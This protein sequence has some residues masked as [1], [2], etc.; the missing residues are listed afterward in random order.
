MVALSDVTK[1]A[2]REAEAGGRIGPGVF[3][4]SAR[5]LHACDTAL[6]VQSGTVPSKNGKAAKNLLELALAEPGLP[7]ERR[8]LS[9]SLPCLQGEADPCPRRPWGAVPYQGSVANPAM[10]AERATLGLPSLTQ[11][12]WEPAPRRRS[13]RVADIP[14]QAETASSPPPGKR[15][16]LS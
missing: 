7:D 10:D 1:E 3:R 2:L 5:V 11:L 14:G 9:Q 12:D 4:D 8:H 6:V 13:P 15:L 16:R